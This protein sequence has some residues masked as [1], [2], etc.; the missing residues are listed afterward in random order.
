VKPEFEKEALQ[1]MND[2]MVKA[3]SEID[4]VALNEAIENM[5]KDHGTNLKENWFWLNA[6]YEYLVHGI[7]VVT[8]YEQIVKAQTPESIAAFARQLYDAGNKIEIVMTPA[9]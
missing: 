2:E 3:C 8:G 7:D 5:A 6:L 1:I 9:E 4:P